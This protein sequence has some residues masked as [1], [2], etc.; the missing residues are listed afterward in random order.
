MEVLVSVTFHGDALNVDGRE[1]RLEAEIETALEV[2]DRIYVLFND[3]TYRRG[4]WRARRNIIAL[5]RDGTE[6]WRVG[7]SGDLFPDVDDEDV[8]FTGMSLKSMDDGA[9]LEVWEP[10]GMLY[11]VN[12][13]TG[14]LSNPVPTKG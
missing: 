14:E 1:F 3:E 5:R 9:V 12:L 2:N 4:D 7:R 8:P 10:I 6:I 13:E 11:D